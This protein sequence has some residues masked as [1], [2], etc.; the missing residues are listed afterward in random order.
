MVCFI[1]CQEKSNCFFQGNVIKCKQEAAAPRL[2]DFIEVLRKFSGGALKPV[3]VVTDDYQIEEEIS[4]V[5]EK[6]V[7]FMKPEPAPKRV[8]DKVSYEISKSF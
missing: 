7:E 1:S 2:L 3:Q 8:L 5:S 4:T 6:D